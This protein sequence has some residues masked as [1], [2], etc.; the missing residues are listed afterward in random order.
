M[1]LRI[2]L[3]AIV[4][5]RIFAAYRRKMMRFITC[6]E[7]M[8]RQKEDFSEKISNIEAGRIEAISHLENMR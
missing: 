5:V 6:V 1:A 4:W 2:I 3:C 8:V 7:E